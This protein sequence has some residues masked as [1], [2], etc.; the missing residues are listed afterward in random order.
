MQLFPTRT[1]SNESTTLETK[2]PHTDLHAEFNNER[3][4]SRLA[5][6]HRPKPYWQQYKKLY[7]AVNG[8]SFLFNLLSI[9]TASALVYFFVLGLTGSATVSAA[10]TALLLFFLEYMKRETSGKLF[11][12]WLQFKSAP[13][14]MVLAVIGLAC[15]STTASYYGADATVRQFTAPVQLE[16]AT[17]ATTETA[18]HIAGIDGQIRD[19]KR[20][21]W[22]GKLTPAA[23]RT[24]DRLTAT[25]ERLIGEQIRTR[26][27]TDQRNDEAENEHATQTNANAQT[28]AAFTLV[29]EIGLI[30]ALFFLQ[31]YDF[32][33]FAEYSHAQRG[34]PKQARPM[35]QSRTQA[36]AQTMTPAAIGFQYS[37]RTE[38]K[39][40]PPPT[41]KTPT[42]EHNGRHCIECGKGYV[43]GH[44]RQKYCSTACRSSSWKSRNL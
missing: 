1:Q 44:A 2:N 32:R 13:A 20:T 4:F 16:S 18:A 24:V 29:C 23:Q 40:V 36:T 43:Y 17:E 41:Q 27:R 6:K 5:E 38:T 26:E 42:F 15:I 12:G 34:A 8:I 35:T 3:L 11:H 39:S 30:V 28:F 22:K 33:S 31:Y 21:T 19:A 14:G 37:G 25:K 9:F 10:L 7:V